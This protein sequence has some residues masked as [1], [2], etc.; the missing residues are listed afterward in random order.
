M[1]RRRILATLPLAA[2][3]PGSWNRDAVDV[4]LVLATDASVSLSDERI[5]LQRE[6]YARAIESEE[7]LRAAAS[8]PLGRVALAAIEWSDRARQD[9]TAPWTLIEDAASARRFAA[10]LRRAPRPIPG[11]TS[12]SGAIDASVGLL[13]RAPYAASRQV[14]D[15]SGN[16]V[17]N[18]GRDAAAARDDAV[19]A[20]ITVNGLPI[21]D[22]APDLDGYYAQAVIGGPRA[23]LVVAR[24]IA[25]FAEAVRRKLVV[26]IA[27]AGESARSPLRS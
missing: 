12:I 15:V 23:F 1:L 9:V 22:V 18:D 25:S 20:G 16:G 27:A 2:M 8:G 6:G 7:F 17:N 26:E 5:T 14:I 21:L 11:F 24:D 13:A 4:V 19:A 3:A 10:M